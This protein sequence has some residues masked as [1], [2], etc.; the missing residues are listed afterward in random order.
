M[1]AALRMIKIAGALLAFGSL[2]ACS[3]LKGGLIGAVQEADDKLAAANGISPAV[4]EKIRSTVGIIDV[5]KL[6][7]QSRILPTGYT[8]RQDILDGEGKPV[9][10]SKFHRGPPYIVPDGTQVDNV[11][12]PADLIVTPGK[13][14]DPAD[15]MAALTTLIQ[16][17]QADPALLEPA[18]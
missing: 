1:N 10:V 17:I 3:S 5:R 15:P 8:W 2:A 7:S 12:L 6:P 9:D 14:V 4:M 11:V 18:E 16:A 13:P